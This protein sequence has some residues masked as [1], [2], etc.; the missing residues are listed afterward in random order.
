MY[1]KRAAGYMER[2]GGYLGRLNIW[3]GW[4]FRE[5]EYIER[6]WRVRNVHFL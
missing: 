3:S 2:E 6:E 1:M 5:A 4:V